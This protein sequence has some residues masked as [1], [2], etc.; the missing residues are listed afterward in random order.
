MVIPVAH[1]YSGHLYPK[2][3]SAPDSSMLQL[4]GG[5]LVTPTLI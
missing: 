4:S 1:E 5:E 3:G 2:S